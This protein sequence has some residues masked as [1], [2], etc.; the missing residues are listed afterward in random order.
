VLPRQVT[1]DID[2]SAGQGGSPVWEMTPDGERYAL[3]IH[4]WGSSRVNGGTRIT[5]EA[6]EDI[7]AWTREAP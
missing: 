3:A 5:K 6:F 4:T 1:Y 7:V 2:T